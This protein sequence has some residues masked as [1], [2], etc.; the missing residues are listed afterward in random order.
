MAAFKI[1]GNMETLLGLISRC[2]LVDIHEMTGFK[3]NADRLCKEER[4]AKQIP[5][6][7]KKAKKQKANTRGAHMSQVTS[8][9]T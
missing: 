9:F 6:S 5:N 7:I 8:N 2:D 4:R 3:D 1:R